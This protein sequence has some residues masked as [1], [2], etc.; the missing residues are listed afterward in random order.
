VSDGTDLE[1]LRAAIKSAKSDERPSLIAVRTVIGHGA[2]NKGGTSASHGAALGAEEVEAT[3]KA[4]DWPHHHPFTVPDDV[5]EHMDRRE[6]GDRAHR[7]W[8]ER[9]AAYRA[10]HPE[11]A[12][13]FERRVIR[14]QL[15]EG[16]ADALPTLDERRCDPQALRRGDQRDR[17]RR[18]ELLRRLGRPRRLQQHRRQG[19][20]G[21]HADDRLGRNLRF[22]V[23]EHAMA[24][25]R[26]A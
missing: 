16:W 17:R 18:P 8:D 7:E 26:T 6:D 14:G 20:R 19:W 13:E 23:R 9:F 15:P 24:R 3:K 2:P 11:L 22:G 12:A 25:S 4:L 5:R 1:A 10:E 21:L